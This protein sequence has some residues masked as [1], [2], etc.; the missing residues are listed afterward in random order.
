MADNLDVDQLTKSNATLLGLPRELRDLIVDDVLLSETHAP[1][2]TQTNGKS[3]KHLKGSGHCRDTVKG[4]QRMQHTIPLLYTCRQMHAETSQRV[5]ALDIPIVL[6]M[7]MT[8]HGSVQ[9]TWLKAPLKR[10]WEKV[11]MQVNVR[12][13]A[14][15][16]GRFR[17][18]RSTGGQRWG[19]L[20]PLPCT[21]QTVWAR[22]NWA[23]ARVASE[24]QDAASYLLRKMLVGVLDAP[25]PLS[26]QNGSGQARGL[27]PGFLRTIAELHINVDAVPLDPSGVPYA[28]PEAWYRP[29]KDMDSFVQE[30]GEHICKYFF[31]DNPPGNKVKSM[32]RQK[33]WLYE[34]GDI[35]AHVGKMEI[36]T[37][38]AVVRRIELEE[39]LRE[40]SKLLTWHEAEVKGPARERRRQ[41]QWE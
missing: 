22:D 8:E 29:E 30:L 10:K 23:Q 32:Y 3:S 9:C 16:V 36:R 31:Y 7:V 4:F 40:G 11:R 24:V 13:Q 18:A 1:K 33:K 6:D 26:S 34:V 28:G 41:L 2:G 20:V 25:V 5:A 37:G 38:G 17:T 39:L 27:G 14:V 19:V 12:V 35:L 21:M 15:N